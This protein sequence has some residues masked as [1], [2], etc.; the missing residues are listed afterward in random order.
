MILRDVFYFHSTINKKGSKKCKFYDTISYIM[1]ENGGSVSFYESSPV[2][3]KQS[4][5][6]SQA[7]I[8]KEMT[9]IQSYWGMTNSS[10]LEGFSSFQ[11][12]FE[13]ILPEGEGN[14]KEYIETTLADKKGVA[15]G[16]EFG[17]PGSL[18]FRAFSDG[19]FAKTAGVNLHDDRID[20]YSD[21]ERN[22]TVIVGDMLANSTQAEVRK[23]LG[24]GNKFDLVF[25]RLLGG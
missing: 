3:R 18:V 14:I 4:H 10:L 9:N 2:V 15:I 24:E 16:I 23:W 20:L 8:A 12:T 13:N 11:N 17:G 22:H 5:A 7:K 1:T 21:E 19:F 6:E 25:E